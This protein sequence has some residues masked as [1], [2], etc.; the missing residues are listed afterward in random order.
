MSLY[1]G[2]GRILVSA[3]TEEVVESTGFV[4]ADAASE[5]GVTR[6]TVVAGCSPV[7]DKDNFPLIDK[8]DK[9]WFISKLSVPLSVEGVKY[10]VVSAQDVLALQDTDEEQA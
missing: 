2:Y 5:G 3:D 10:L 6:A 4:V 1:P 8:G 9:V 7:E